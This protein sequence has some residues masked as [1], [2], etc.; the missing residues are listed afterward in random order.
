MSQSRIDLIIPGLFNLPAHELDAQALQRITPALHQL[1]RFAHQQAV[2]ACDFDD[3]LLQRLGLKQAA[4][5]WAQAMQGDATGRTM[6]FR[7]V[8][9]KADINN[10]IVFPVDENHDDIDFVI[11]DLAEFFKQDCEI[12][13]LPDGHWLMMLKSVRP[14]DGAPHYL[15]ALG[16][17]VTHYLEQ[18]RMNLDWFRLF[19]EMQM[20]LHQHVVNQRRQQNGQLLINSLWCWGADDYHG[21]KLPGV[22]WFSDEVGLDALGNLF[23]ATTHPLSDLSAD[24]PG[25]EAIIIDL[26]LLKALKQN[27]DAD[28][29]KILEKLEE[30]CFEPLLKSKAAITLHSGSGMNLQYQ[31][32]M[33]WQRWKRP[34]SLAGFPA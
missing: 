14:V 15:S 30:E 26:S 3:I 27:P 19:N 34:V 10:A 22:H 7:P 28:L 4:L 31:P 11:N 21:E 13:K 9:L 5:P 16:K 6:L 12:K 29:M 20:F 32:R 24:A 25:G 2:K 8:Y 33:S 23:D 17:K 18:A 1:L